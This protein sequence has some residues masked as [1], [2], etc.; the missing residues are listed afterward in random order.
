VLLA[1]DSAPRR[2]LLEG[3]LLDYAWDGADALI[4][5]TMHTEAPLWTRFSAAFALWRVPVTTLEPRE[6]A[7]DPARLH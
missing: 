3:E 1:G 4:C 2:V 5:L 7:L 6:L